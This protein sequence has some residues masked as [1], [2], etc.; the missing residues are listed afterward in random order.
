MANNLKIQ[1]VSTLDKELSLIELN[2]KISELEG[3]VGKIKLEIK[4][5]ETVLKKLNDIANKIQNVGKMSM[6]SGKLVE[7]ANKKDAK[8]VDDLTKRYS[9]LISEVKKYKA[10]GSLKGTTSTYQDDKGNGR[11]INTN[12]KNEVTN[13]KDI[14]N[15]QKFQKEQ[16]K[17]RKGLIELARTGKYSSDEL[18]KIGQG[19]HLADTVKSLN[20]LQ[21]RMSNMKSGNSLANDQE[22]LRQAL[23]KVYDQGGMNEQRFKRFNSLINSSKNVAEIDKIQKAMNRVSDTGKNKNLQQNL[24]SQAQTLLGGN[25]K[26]L[27]VTGVNN[28][29]NSLKNIQ[30]NAANASNQLKR[31]QQE[32]KQYQAEAKVAGAH[33]LTFGSALKQA[34]AG[35]SLWSLTAQAVYAPVRALQDMTQRLIEVDTLMTDIRRVMDMPDF[36]FTELLQEAV[37]T[38]DTLSSKLTDVLGIMGS[39][40]R[41]GFDENQL[42][43][44][45]K[46]AQ[47]LQNISDLDATSSV[48]T[49]TSAMLNFGI[50]ANKSIEI[51]DK[52][53][54]V[55]LI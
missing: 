6:E 7:D 50:A 41:M 34:L 23:K 21:N 18:R 52:L 20:N 54:E 45:T 4:V 16:E 48:D 29:V 10:D 22:K 13:Y 19:I 15:I 8:S 12:A 38:S 32:L 11:V 51:A 49:L 40:G 47:V 37:D 36:K 26:K 39:F 31:L 46:T 44:I 25:S 1:L 53:N 27:D 24:L 14:E 55:D 33:T 35:F 2:K 5:D 3:K 43:D 30:P 42:V 17:L 28:L 9:K